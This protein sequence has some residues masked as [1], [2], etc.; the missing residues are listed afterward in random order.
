MVI[1]T[2]PEHTRKYA[3]KMSLPQGVLVGALAENTF[4]SCTK[5]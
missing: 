2:E 5:K 1:G 4:V 3:Y